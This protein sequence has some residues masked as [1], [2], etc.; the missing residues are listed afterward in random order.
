MLGLT[1]LEPLRRGERECPL[2]GWLGASFYPNTGPGYHEPATHCPGCLSQARHRFLTLLLL[3]RT[4]FFREPQR[5]VEVAPMRGFEALCRAHPLLDYVSFDLER[6]AME[7]GDLTALHYPDA[8]FDFFICFHVLEHIPAERA[9]LAEIWRV[10][11]PGGT[12]V[13]QVPIDLE[14][15][16]TVEY[17]KPDPR[18]AHHVRRHGRDFPDR[19]RAAGFAVEST[20]AADVADVHERDRLGLCEEPIFFARRP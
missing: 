16:V 20:T 2:C 18:D 10:L 1:L 9:A 3:R 4:G 6:Y 15:A 11:K 8:H 17:G 13:L 14:L 12:A 7:R 5:V 19:L